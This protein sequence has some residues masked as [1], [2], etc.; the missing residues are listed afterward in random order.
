MT[1]SEMAGERVV[2]RLAIPDTERMKRLVHGLHRQES[3]SL[4]PEDLWGRM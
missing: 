4:R 3:I 2:S 1:S